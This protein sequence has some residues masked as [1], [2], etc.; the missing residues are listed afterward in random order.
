MQ[1]W[2][3][4]GIDQLEK[5]GYLSVLRGLV[6]S[7][8][9][10]IWWYHDRRTA[11]ES[12]L[13]SG[14]VALVN[15]G[16]KVIAITANHVYEQ[17]LLDKRRDAEV[18]CQ[19]GSVTVEPERY[20]IA[21]DANLDMATFELPVVL[22]TA[23]GAIAHNAPTWPPPEL[24]ESELAILGGYPGNRRSENSRTIDSDFVSLIS[25][26][27]QSSEGHISIHLNTAESH[28]PQGK[29][30]VNSPDLGGMSGGPVFRIRTEPLEAI[31]FAGTIYESHQT[32]EIVRARHASYIRSDGT[33]RR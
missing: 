11:G 6:Q 29:R 18:K 33:I 4:A 16:C 7:H 27:G 28:W 15:T 32:Y 17:Y 23:T 19:F 21:A 2:Q 9:C 13:H 24:H 8:T 26:V 12:I 3:I 20:V 5:L 10:P 25:R 30:L 14:T 31:E 1:P 22:A